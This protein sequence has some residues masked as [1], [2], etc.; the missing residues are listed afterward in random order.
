M[1]PI[2]LGSLLGFGFA[3]VAG[4][5]IGVRYERSRQLRPVETASRSATEATATDTRA[6]AS[7]GDDVTVE[8][9]LGQCRSGHLLAVARLD[10][11]DDWRRT[12]GQATVDGL[13]RQFRDALAPIAEVFVVEKNR[14]RLL[15]CFEKSDTGNASPKSAS[16]QH[17]AFDQQSEAKQ[18]SESKPHSNRDEADAS[19]AAVTPAIQPLVEALR[20]G[21]Y[22]D[23]RD[24]VVLATASF[25]IVELPVK[26]PGATAEDVTR[27]AEAAF[28]ASRLGRNQACLWQSG[29]IRRIPRLK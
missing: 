5:L 19:A 23:L 3:V 28:E 14:D 12:H 13:L 4:F 25:G 7:V 26:P 27:A 20:N 17:K 21:E 1:G 6:T 16:P 11:A 2:L 18:Q 9:F 24:G 15:M 8:E 22:R 29:R 10:A